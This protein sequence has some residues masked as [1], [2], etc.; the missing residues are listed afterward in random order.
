MYVENGVVEILCQIILNMEKSL[1][2]NYHQFILS[3]LNQ[4]FLM[5]PV[6]VK[7]IC[8]NMQN[9]N[10]VLCELQDSY[11]DGTTYQVDLNINESQI[12]IILI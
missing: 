4:L 8:S 1:D 9:L 10:Q 3:S 12:F 7:E 6:K 5:S 2:E 11:S